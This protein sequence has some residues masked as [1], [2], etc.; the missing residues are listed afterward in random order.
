MPRH[1]APGKSLQQGPEASQELLR[2]DT[3]CLA[4]GKALP[5]ERKTAR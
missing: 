5:Q 4:N 1:A 3:Y 2:C